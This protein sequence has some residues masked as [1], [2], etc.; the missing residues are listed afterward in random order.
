MSRKKI[1]EKGTKEKYEKD[2]SWNSFFSVVHGHSLRPPVWYT[3]QLICVLRFALIFCSGRRLNKALDLSFGQTKLYCDFIR[4]FRSN[5]WLNLLKSAFCDQF[6]AVRVEW[7]FQV[8]EIRMLIVPRNRIVGDIEKCCR[9]TEQTCLV[10]PKFIDLFWDWH[11]SLDNCVTGCT[12]H[13]CDFQSDAFKSQFSASPL[14][15]AIC[16]I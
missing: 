3:S 8:I 6:Y 9:L 4:S 12:R 2:P 13:L 5:S 14:I 16:S 11:E 1:G 15:E 7:N 10:R